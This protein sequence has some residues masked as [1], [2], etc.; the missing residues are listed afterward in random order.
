MKYPN[1]IDSNMVGKYPAHVYSGGGGF[2]DEVLEYRVWVHPKDGTDYYKAFDTYDEALT[3][4]KSTSNAE[5]PLVLVYQEEYIDESTPGRYA[6]V[7]KPRIAEW[8][9]EW[10]GRK[11]KGTKENILHFLKDNQK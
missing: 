1:A 9:P 10:L 11:P 5:Q 7:I 6:H 2:Y 8:L 3:F 4:S